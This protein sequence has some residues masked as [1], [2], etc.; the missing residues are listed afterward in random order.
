MNFLCP[1]CKLNLKCDDSAAGQVVRCPSCG[2][3][4]RVPMPEPSDDT[5]AN[6]EGGRRE[7]A[8]GKTAKKAIAKG[9]GGGK[10]GSQ[11]AAWE[12]TDSSNVSGAISLGIGVV[13]MIVVY[14]MLFPFRNAYLGQLFYARGWIP[15]VLVMFLGWSLAIL[16]LKFR[17]LGKQ[18]R[19]MLFDVLPES[20]AKEITVH[21]VSDFL[22][23]MA[24]VPETL[25]GCLIVKRMKLGLQHFSVR[26]SNPEVANMMMSQSE[27]DAGTINSSYALLKVF[28]W[29]IPILGF[30]GTVLGISNAVAG[31]S[32]SLEGAADIAVLKES[33]G[34]VTS[35]LAVAFD[36][37]LVAL[38]LSVIIS[39]PSSSMQKAEEDLLS[40]VDAYCNENLLKRLNDG[41]GVLGNAQ[42][43]SESAIQS[44][45]QI[46]T[47]SQHGI[48]SEFRQLQTHMSA[49]QDDQ[50]AIIQRM[51]EAVDEQL[52]SMEKRA[53]AHQDALDETMGGVVEPIRKTMKELRDNGKE[54]DLQASEVIAESAKSIKSYMAALTGGIEG[55]NKVLGQLGEKQVVIQQ[56]S[57]RGW[58]PFS[59]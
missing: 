32:G 36:T 4:L 27:I 1:H 21:N 30:I 22:A 34:N 59:R 3:K 50:A 42:G 19:A 47:Q 14:L 7:S 58:W 38:V 53:T 13:F 52:G 5:Q 18:R 20:I 45:G 57:R 28:L 44:M 49:V 43:G 2:G 11:K 35:G 16:G 48:L 39:F 17:M 8:V 55:L 26:H 37:T 51:A 12:P 6:K 56:T 46:L 29:A 10:S 25:Q 33:L 41:G 23:H 31:F 54:V 24:K 15:F 40:W 9:K